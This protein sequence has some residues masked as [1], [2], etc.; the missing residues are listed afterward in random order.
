MKIVDLENPDY[1]GLLREIDSSPQK[2]YCKGKWDRGIFKNCLAVVGSRRMTAYGARITTELVSEIASAGITIVSGFMY[3]VDARAHQ[4]ALSSQGRTIAVMPCGIDRI[5]P[6]YQKKLYQQILN[7]KGLIISETAGQ[8]AP[9]SWSYPR[10]NRIVAGLS[11]A[12]LVVEAALGSGSLITA[13]LAKKYGRKLFALPGPLTSS[14][15]AGSLRLIKEGAEMVTGASDVLNYYGLKVASCFQNK[16][17]CSSDRLEGKIMAELKKEPLEADCLARLA[18]V[19][20]STI[21]VKLSY[22]QLKGLV[23]QKDGKYYV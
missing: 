22:M 2:L 8:S 5:H 21:G 19:S 13:S 9:F 11:Q 10:R 16:N 1:P 20:I 12:T 4:A 3:G 18:K 6:A 14:V 15:S 17:F 7:Q 23:E